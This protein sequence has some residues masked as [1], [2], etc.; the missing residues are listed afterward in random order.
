MENF[1]KLMDE[2]EKAISTADHLAYVT[3][4][5]VRETK[6]ILNVIDHLYNAVDKSMKAILHYDCYYKRIPMFDEDFRNQFRILKDKCARRY[7]ISDKE[8]KTI[9]DLRE[10]WEN[11]KKVRWVLVVMINLCFMG[12]NTI[13]KQ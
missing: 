2:A 10:I 12:V 5:M 6:L 3:Y 13:C 8:L 4:P 11:S 1:N 7:K 9:Y